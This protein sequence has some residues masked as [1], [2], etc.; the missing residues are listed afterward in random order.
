RIDL[1]DTG[2]KGGQLSHIED[3]DLGAMLVIVEATMRQLAVK[4]HLAA[5]KARTDAAAGT[6]RLALAAATG[7]LAVAA[8]FAAANALLAV[9]G[10]GDVLQFV[11][12]HLDS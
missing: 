11:E 2:I 3:G 6:G 7:G 12:F 4:R 1:A 10:T 9:H 8:S 5:F